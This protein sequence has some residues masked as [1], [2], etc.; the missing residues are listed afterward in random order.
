MNKGGYVYIIANKNFTVLYTGV[1]SDLLARVLQH[2]EKFYPDS[3]TAKYNCCILV[4]YK[5]F[6]SIEE[7]I[8]E[9]KRLKGGSRIKKIKLIE[10]INPD[11]KDLWEE[12]KRW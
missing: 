2:K 1:T 3:F 7:A 8:F 12:I 9:E 11:W 5:F 10:E 4:Y 6:S